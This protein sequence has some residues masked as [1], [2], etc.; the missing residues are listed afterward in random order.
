[1]TTVADTTKSRSK[2]LG[3]PPSELLGEPLK[4]RLEACHAD[5]FGWA[6]ACSAGDLDLAEEALSTTYLK[7]LE[8]RARFAGRSR[9]KTWLFGVIRLSV[10][11]LRRRRAWRRFVPVEW[12]AEAEDPQPPRSSTIV[13]DEESANLRRALG[14][15]G[16]R[17]RQ[18]LHLVFYQEMTVED[19]SS[20]LGI[21]VG[22]ARTHY[23]RGKSRLRRLLEETTP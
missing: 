2:P 10:V 12:L 5:S 9:F 4:H 11:E 16:E 3:E 15:L 21:G 14:A 22:T 1:M 19:A 18:V 7:V 17:Q 23:Q 6:L 8:G 13:E 20:V